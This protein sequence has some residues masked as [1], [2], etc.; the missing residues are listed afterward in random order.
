MLRNNGDKE[1]MVDES[2]SNVRISLYRDVLNRGDDLSIKMG[3]SSMWPFIKDGETVVVRRMRFEDIVTGDVIVVYVNGRMICHRVFRKKHRCIQTKA[4]ALTG[5]DAEISERNILGKV[6][7]QK[8]GCH[9]RRCEGR[10][11]SLVGR[12]IAWGTL[13]WAPL[14]PGLRRLKK[15][16]LNVIAV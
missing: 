15:Y 1:G 12:C 9:T 2:A 4:D 16:V 5:L 11:S 8:R 10:V 7:A 14:I 3:G 6:I 13:V